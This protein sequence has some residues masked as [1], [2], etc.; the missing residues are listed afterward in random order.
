MRSIAL[1]FV[2]TILVAG[3]PGVAS[4]ACNGRLA[5]K[6]GPTGIKLQVC[7]DGKYATCLRDG[8]RLGW[9]NFQRYCDDLLD[10]GRVSR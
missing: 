2:M 7:L 3:V 4:A 8:Q 6:T 1:A 10:K 5:T 9:L